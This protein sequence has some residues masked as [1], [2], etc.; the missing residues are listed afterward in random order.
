MNLI[1]LLLLSGM[2]VSLLLY[3]GFFRTVLRDRLI[4]VVI[5]GVAMAAILF[6]D[7]TTSVANLLG[8][9]RGADLLIY[10]FV[11]GS[12]FAFILVGT[13]MKAME[14][15]ITRLVRQ[16]AIGNAEHPAEATPGANTSAPSTTNQEQPTRTST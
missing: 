16:I 14:E 2:A 15:S 13:R 9:G 4:A 12:I 11:T 8:V 3:L 5:F 1:Q 10:I 7:L 6:P